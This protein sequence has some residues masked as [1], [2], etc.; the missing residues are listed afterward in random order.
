MISAVMDGSWGCGLLKN[1]YH[2]DGFKS[3][4]TQLHL[5]L[6]I[7]IF[8]HIAILRGWEIT[9]RR[10]VNKNSIQ[11]NSPLQLSNTGELLA[12]SGL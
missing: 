9:V 11:N 10:K 7:L 12:H 6:L 3:P 5:L 2:S 4:I 1:W 8:T